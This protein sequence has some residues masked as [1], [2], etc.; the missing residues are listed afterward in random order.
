MKI[1][2]IIGAIVLFVGIM[3]LLYKLADYSEKKMKEERKRHIEK[4]ALY[5]QP[6]F[7]ESML[8]TNI[9]SRTKSKII[10][11]TIIVFVFLLFV[12]NVNKIILIII[13]VSSVICVLMYVFAKDKKIPI[14]L[15]VIIIVICII[16]S[17]FYYINTTN[18]NEYNRQ[19][20]QYKEVVTTSKNF[21]ISDIEGFID[22]V[23]RNNNDGKRSISVQYDGNTYQSEDELDELLSKLDL[24]QKYTFDYEPKDNY[25]ETIY[26]YR[27]LT[28]DEKIMMNII[29]NKNSN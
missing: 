10:C 25:I 2:W 12:L 15:L 9:H 5:K 13:I 28:A 11:L 4:S 7:L 3:I 29:N 23:K 14:I 1:L 18:I 19:F 8:Y 17:I 20:L 21:Y 27:Y 22:T 16:I 24:N 6:S 26:I